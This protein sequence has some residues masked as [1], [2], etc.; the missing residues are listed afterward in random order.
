MNK[1]LITYKSILVGYG[2]CIS[3]SIK[4]TDSYNRI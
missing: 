2:C 1:L 4:E 3:I